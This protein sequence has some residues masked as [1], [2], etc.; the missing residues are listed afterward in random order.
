MKLI[1]AI[2]LDLAKQVFQV[3]GAGANGSPFISRKLRRADVLAL[4]D[5][6]SRCLE[7]IPLILKHIHREQNSLRTLLR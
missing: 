2:G 4:F 7:R 5:K 3:Y 1:T 6:L